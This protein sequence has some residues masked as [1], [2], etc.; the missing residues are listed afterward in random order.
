[1]SAWSHPIANSTIFASYGVFQ[2]GQLRRP[3]GKLSL[4]GRKM[5]DWRE[6]TFDGEREKRM[7]L[8]TDSAAGT[9]QAVVGHMAVGIAAAEQKHHMAAGIVAEV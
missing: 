8:A 3:F 1:L 2:K 9:V 6:D 5:V 4:G 7:A